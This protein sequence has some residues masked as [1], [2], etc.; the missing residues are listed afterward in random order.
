MNASFKLC[1]DFLSVGN[2]KD[3]WLS[4]NSLLINLEPKYLALGQN[5]T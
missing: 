5:D 4:P 2:K 1:D 3:C